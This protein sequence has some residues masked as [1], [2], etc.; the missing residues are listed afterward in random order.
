MSLTSLALLTIRV[1]EGP[2]EGCCSHQ[3]VPVD[4]E[5]D[6]PASVHNPVLT[7]VQ[8]NVKPNTTETRVGNAKKELLTLSIGI[9][10]S[11]FNCNQTQLQSNQ[12]QL[13][14]N[15]LQSNLIAFKLNCNQINCIQTQLQSNL[16]AF[17]L[18]CNQ[19]NCIQ[20]QLQSVTIASKTQLRS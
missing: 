20:T 9:N 8:R 1:P 12:T 10:L 4:V 5:A 13:Q 15:Q 16:I 6:L 2:G 3:T 17:K 19:I 14:S 11:T 7:V 18:N